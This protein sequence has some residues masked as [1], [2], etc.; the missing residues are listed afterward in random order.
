MY[1]EKFNAVVNWFPKD[2]NSYLPSR[3]EGWIIL[4]DQRDT[5]LYLEWLDERA[6]E[7]VDDMS[8][9]NDHLFANGEDIKCRAA[10]YS[11]YRIFP[12]KD[13]ILVAWV[14]L[15]KK[16]KPYRVISSKK[17]WL[18]QWSKKWSGFQNIG[19]AVGDTIE[20][21][22]VMDGMVRECSE[23]SQWLILP[24]WKSLFKGIHYVSLGS[25]ILAIA[26][27]EDPEETDIERWVT[28]WRITLWWDVENGLYV[29]SLFEMPWVVPMT[30]ET[31]YDERLRD[32]NSTVTKLIESSY[33]EWLWWIYKN[34]AMELIGRGSRYWDFVKKDMQAWSK[35]EFEVYKVIADSI[36]DFVFQEGTEE[37]VDAYLTSLN[38]RIFAITS[39]AKVPDLPEISV[40]QYRQWIEWRRKVIQEFGY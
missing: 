20:S 13:I 12:D 10:L 40:K 21:E 34:R 22:W 28:E 7:K 2:V 14:K 38:Q 3:E 17:L 26:R 18:T 32:K 39:I 33:V 35:L 5:N 30:A 11:L 23:E 15:T 6:K 24:E 1:D 27:I 37:D 25:K 36:T 29:D 4:W 16:G 9:N 8:R 19:W 31:Y